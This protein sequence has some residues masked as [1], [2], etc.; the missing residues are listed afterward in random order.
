M[1][2]SV[3]IFGGTFDPVHIGHEDFLQNAQ[4]LVCPDISLVIPCAIPPHKA[5]AHTKGELRAKMCEAL[6]VNS[7]TKVYTKELQRDGKSYTIDTVDLLL[8]EYNGAKLYLC[9]GGDMLLYFKKWY[10]YEQ[11]IQKVVLV[12]Q[13]RED[14]LAKVREMAQRLAQEGADII[15]INAK[16]IQVSSTQLRQMVKQGESISQLVPQKVNEIIKQ[17]NLYQGYNK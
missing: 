13:S 8:K 12:V 1:I 7:K 3:L 6:C 15:F 5:A 11:I 10:K 9:V 4:Q 2:N 14:N 17:H 16:P